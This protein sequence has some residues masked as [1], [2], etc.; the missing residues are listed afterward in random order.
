MFNKAGRKVF[1]PHSLWEGEL[2]NT[3]LQTRHGRNFPPPRWPSLLTLPSQ[4]LSQYSVYLEDIWSLYHEHVLESVD[5]P[6]CSRSRGGRNSKMATNA[7][8][9][10][11][12][13]TGDTN[14]SR[15]TILHMGSVSQICPL[16]PQLH[17]KSCYLFTINKLL[18]RDGISR[19]LHLPKLCSQT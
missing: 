12:S 10:E 7:H 9:T 2:G 16:K 14:I 6:F 17:Q 1:L 5:L 4:P 15:V 3:P 11:L 8:N 18:A 19:Y 13:F